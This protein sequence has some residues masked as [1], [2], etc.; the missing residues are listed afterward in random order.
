MNHAHDPVRPRAQRGSVPYKLLLTVVACSLWAQEFYPFSWFPM[1]TN[2]QK[3]T[4]Y[5]FVK[6]GAGSTIA[7]GREFGWTGD[8]ADNYYK[9]NLS[10][11]RER[12]PDL[13]KDETIR[14]IAEKMLRQLHALPAHS[15]SGA[16][17]DRV[18]ELWRTDIKLRDGSLVAMDRPI[19]RMSRSEAA[20]LEAANVALPDTG[21]DGDYAEEADAGDGSDR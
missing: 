17:P 8:R 11:L 14:Q 18:L 19:A 10:R 12:H 4:W 21:P 13:E 5:V 20:A 9:S 6:D 2:L 3:S 15:R 1:F 16:T 7:L